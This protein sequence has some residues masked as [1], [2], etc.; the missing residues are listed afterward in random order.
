MEKEAIESTVANSNNLCHLVEYVKMTEYL[1]DKVDRI[2]QAWVDTDRKHVKE[3]E[4]VQDVLPP[5]M[6]KKPRKQPFR[7]ETS[8]LN[9]KACSFEDYLEV[10]RTKMLDYESALPPLP[11]LAR[12]HHPSPRT[13]VV[14]FRLIM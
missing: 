6:R 8:K 3:I 12:L 10:S 5:G 4:R 13:R 11:L 1:K 2:S 9:M 14:T 7:V